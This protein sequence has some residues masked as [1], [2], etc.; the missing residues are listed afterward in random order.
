MYNLF[1][2]QRFRALYINNTLLICFFYMLAPPRGALFFLFQPYFFFNL[3]CMMQLL[4]IVQNKFLLRIRSRVASANYF[5]M[6]TSARRPRVAIQL[7]AVIGRDLPRNVNVIE[8][9]I[10]HLRL[11]ITVFFVMKKKDRLGEIRTADLPIHQRPLYPFD[12]GGPPAFISFIFLSSSV[13]LNF[14]VS[15]CLYLIF[16]IYMLFATSPSLSFRIWFEILLIAKSLWFR[17]FSSSFFKS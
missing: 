16:D 15:W 14:W 6:L 8:P 10:P 9:R 12:H 3:N 5:Y 13:N 17:A 4:Y 2:A 11:R 1:E 7:V